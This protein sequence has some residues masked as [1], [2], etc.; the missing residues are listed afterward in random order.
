M[1]D[2]NRIEPFLK[3]LGAVWKRNPDLRFTQL[4]LCTMQRYGNDMFY[5]ED[6]EFLEYLFKAWCELG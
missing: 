1:R 5:V 6:E 4:I 2:E 3:T